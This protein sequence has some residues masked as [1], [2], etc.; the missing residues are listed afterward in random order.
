MTGLPKNRLKSFFL[1]L[2]ILTLNIAITSTA[3]ARHINTPEIYSTLT[4]DTIPKKRNDSTALQTND[5]LSKGD[6]TVPKTDT[7]SLRI[8]KDTLDAPVDYEAEDSAVLLVKQKKFILYGKTKVT[9]KDIV[10]TSPKVEM[11]QQ[12]NLITAYGEK[13][14]LGNVITRA[15]FT[16]GDQTFQSEFIQYNF[17]SGRGLTQNTITQ[18]DELYIHGEKIKRAN[19]NTVFI[20][21]G[22][23]TT[24]NLDEPHFH[25][26][27]DRVKVIHNKLAVT[28]YVQLAFEDVPLP[29]P[30]GL[31]FGFFPLNQG[32]RSGLLPVQFTTN[33]NFGLGIEGIG[34][35]HVFNQ[36]WDVTLRGNVY[37]YGGWLANITPQYR[38]RYRYNGSFNI[39]I[40]HTRINFK[41]DPD[42]QNP[43]TYSLQ[44]TH[45]VDRN[46]RPGT[47][48][49]A[50]VNISS[51][52]YNELLS[53]SFT[54]NF[55]NRNF[56]NML[57]SSIAY[58]KMFTIRGG[59]F[60]GHPI[61]LQLNAGHDQNNNLRLINI[62]LP[63]GSLA[64]TTIYPF[65]R[66]EQVG[67]KKW[68]E[69]IGVGYNS[70]FRN[71]ISFYD[72][73]GVTIN[74]L[75]DT[76]QWGARH[77]IPITM[78][79]PPIAGGKLILSPNISY[80]EVWI[81]SQIK[82]GW[83]STTRKIDTLSMTKG[84]YT[85]RQMSF[86]LG[87]NTAIFGTFYTKRRTGITAIRHVIR[88]TI[89]AN[90]KPNLSKNKYD[91]IDVDTSGRKV[92]LPRLLGGYGYGRFGGLTFGIDNN[93]EMKYRGKKDT[94]ERK[95]RLIDGFA[96]NSGYN[97]L[98][99]SLQLQQFNIQL[100]STLFE[101]VNITGQA[102]L[103]PYN[104]DTLGFRVN[105]FMWD[106]QFRL[107]RFTGGS[108]SLSTNFRSK[109][110][111]PS[112]SPQGRSNNLS[113]DLRAEEPSSLDDQLRMEEYM[114]RNP[115]E[116]I[117]FN[118]PWSFDLNFSLVFGRQFDRSK[119]KFT[120]TITSNASFNNSFSLTPKW[121]FTTSGFYDFSSMELTSL[122][123]SI[124]RDMHC[125]QMS[126]SVVPIGPFRSFNISINPKAAILQDL[127][128]NRTRVFNNY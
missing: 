116:F 109:P 56:Q 128:V 80:E 11:D 44:W 122:N 93:L 83:N 28:G 6:S 78:S 115:A 85:D 37:S 52:R 53:N 72:T 4:S 65:Q 1:S 127:K 45:S 31:P 13:D 41:G 24:C 25:F 62:R 97:F 125:W 35:H 19:A 63:E 90:Y 94:A 27:A 106:G 55:Q 102:V 98:E 46:A 75:L 84:F 48:F 43:K 21:D 76:L 79:L 71:Q 32:R 57:Q 22:K 12:T 103:D 74:K 118:I 105:R 107:P 47:T 2:V 95:I 29:K 96:I 42:F 88:P 61:N 49:G 36:Y 20:A 50:N 100:R 51:S 82:R 114:R 108:I 9:H 69:N 99:D 17:K 58:S 18:Q 111:D 87:M 120:S 91:L 54:Q 16:Q 67:A 3:E 23:L 5:S 68:Y 73:A 104:V 40:Q 66:A 101:K 110:R 77:S 15:V 86:G 8:S 119:Q 10:L 112:I 123:M 113:P 30:I 26:K 39:G 126:V 70:S 89:S 60:D 7:F 117:D 64:I 14:S 59:K 124:S 121:N 33:E 34:Y 81:Q 92:P 38:K